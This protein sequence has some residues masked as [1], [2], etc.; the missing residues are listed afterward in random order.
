[1]ERSYKAE[2]EADDAQIITVYDLYLS[3]LCIDCAAL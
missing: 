1:M 2:D 3:L